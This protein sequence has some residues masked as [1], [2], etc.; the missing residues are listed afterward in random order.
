MIRTI[1]LSLALAVSLPLAAPA[2]DTATLADIRQQLTTLYSDIQ[3]L[4]SELT[5]SGALTQGVAG[6]T[7]LDRLNAIEAELTRLTAKAEQLEYRINQVVSDGTN[8]IGDL[9]FRLCEL[10]EGCD[11][12]TLGDTPSLGGAAPATDGAVTGATPATGG[13]SAVPTTPPPAA[14]QLAVAEQGDFDAALAMM[15][16]GDFAGAV[17]GFEAFSM[18]YPGSP[19]SQR[20]HYLRGESY[21]SM[22]EMTNAARAYLDAFSANQT[23][24]GAP[25]ALFKLGFSLGAIGQTQDACITLS[26]VPTRFPNSDAALDAQAAARGLG[27]Q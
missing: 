2:Q 22:G 4:K 5:T 18:T 17:A 9:E 21:E 6:S 1:A 20:A 26:L 25:D 8:R 16:E 19:L 23:G 24:D 12:S 7:P 27:C 13:P 3:S 14:P 10:E 15:E 11:I